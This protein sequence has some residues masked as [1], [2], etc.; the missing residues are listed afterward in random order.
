MGLL[1]EFESIKFLKEIL[2]GVGKF[3]LWL[4]KSEKIIHTS[5][6]SYFV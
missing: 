3:D 5:F 2:H 4:D 1:V 6:F